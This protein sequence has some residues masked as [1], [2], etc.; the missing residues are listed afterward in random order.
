MEEKTNK[1]RLDKFINFQGYVDHQNVKK[2]YKRLS[3]FIAVST[4][5]SF[6]V[7]ILEAAAFGISIYYIE[8]WWT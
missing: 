8:R 2:Y 4:S 5:E 6:G 7:S 1:K 3:V